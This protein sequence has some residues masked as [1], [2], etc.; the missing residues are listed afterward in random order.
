MKLEHLT[1]ELLEPRLIKSSN[2]GFSQLSGPLTLTRQSRPERG[3][4]SRTEDR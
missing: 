1:S 4:T 2:L 3:S